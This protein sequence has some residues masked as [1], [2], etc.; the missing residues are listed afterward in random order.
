MLFG[1]QLNDCQHVLRSF[2]ANFCNDLALLALGIHKCCCEAA[3]DPFYY[4]SAKRNVGRQI[5]VLVG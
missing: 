5:K 3:V 2:E 1:M 4:I